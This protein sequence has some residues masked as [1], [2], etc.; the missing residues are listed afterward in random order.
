MPSSLLFHLSTLISPINVDEKTSSNVIVFIQSWE[1]YLL[2][3]SSSSSTNEA[4]LVVAQ[5]LTLLTELTALLEDN[6]AILTTR[7]DGTYARDESNRYTENLRSLIDSIEA[8]SLYDVGS[9][10]VKP[11]PPISGGI[12]GKIGT[13]FNISPSE[14]GGANQGEAIRN[15][16]P[17]NDGAK[18]IST[19]LDRQLGRLNQVHFA[20]MFLLSWP[21]HRCG[22][23]N[24]AAVLR[25]VVV[26]V[27]KLGDRKLLDKET[28]CL[29][30]QLSSILAYVK[31]HS[32]P[33]WFW[34]CTP[35]DWAKNCSIMSLY[36]SWLSKELLNQTN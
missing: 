21:Y 12:V 25:D 26:A 17:S 22:G 31:R 4:F 2:E 3:K 10:I 36:T 1:S 18:P 7:V 9:R 33:A 23:R 20:T 11:T 13:D 35:A 28:G 15:T 6:T 34:V 29:R 24:N 19:E 14:V 32:K 5:A 30:Q 27:L 8:S 16:I